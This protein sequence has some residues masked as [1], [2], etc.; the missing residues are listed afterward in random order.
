MDDGTRLPAR[1]ATSHR[2][3]RAQPRTKKARRTIYRA[4]VH[5]TFAFAIATTLLAY[6]GRGAS[7]ATVFCHL[8]LMGMAWNAV[9]LLLVD[10]LLICTLAS[11][12]FIF[13]NT[14]H[15]AGRHDFRFHWM[16]FVKGCVAM[17][18]ISGVLAVLTFRLMH[19]TR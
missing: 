2:P 17:S 4:G 3:A 7:F 10:W 1:Y 15:C 11:P 8:W 18:A 9:D 16:G 6:A 14:A 13:P 12:L 5:P 19:L